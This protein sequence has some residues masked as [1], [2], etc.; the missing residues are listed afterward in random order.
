MSGP[1]SF[2]RLAATALAAIA[3]T[4]CVSVVDN[5]NE[6]AT[7]TSGNEIIPEY[8]TTPGRKCSTTGL[9]RFRG[10]RAT[11]AIGQAIVERSKAASL[12]WIRPSDA[13]TMDFRTDRI[14]VSLDAASKIASMRC[15]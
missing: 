1:A 7:E 9:D 12:R 13:V 15:G 14:N 11:Q 3:C 8:G 2:V 4:A 10:Q 5:K 6:P